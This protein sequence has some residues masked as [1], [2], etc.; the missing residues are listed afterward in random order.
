MYCRTYCKI[1]F[2]LLIALH[3]GSAFANEDGTGRY[4]AQIR[5]LPLNRASMEAINRDYLCYKCMA[6]CNTKN[7]QGKDGVEKKR[8]NTPSMAMASEECKM[9]KQEAFKKMREIR[10][11]L[12]V[13]CNHFVQKTDMEE[14]LGEQTIKLY[15]SYK[16]PEY[17]LKTLSCEA[18][19]KGNKIAFQH[20]WFNV[21]SNRT[22]EIILTNKREEE[23]QIALEQV[24][25]IP[26]SFAEEPY[27]WL[28]KH[29]S[30]PGKAYDFV[31]RKKSLQVNLE[32]LIHDFS[33]V[34]TETN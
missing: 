10:E 2:F 21:F 19:E 16:K 23:M 11:M 30:L 33:Q 34:N 24:E 6:G 5:A 28:V 25:N 13:Q 7:T 15:Q 32:K 31:S 14:S 1:A 26:A 29:I 8:D 17:T 20:S 18:G 9:V 27:V 3:M 4:L 12:E 22:A